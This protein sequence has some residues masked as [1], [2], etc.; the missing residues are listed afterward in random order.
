MSASPDLGGEAFDVLGAAGDDDH[1]VAVEGGGRFGR[2]ELDEIDKPLGEQVGDPLTSVAFGVDDVR[3]AD[4]LQDPA[5][6]AGDRF[7]PDQSGVPSRRRSP[8]SRPLS[9]GEAPSTTTTLACPLIASLPSRARV[10]SLAYCWP[11]D[12]ECRFASVLVACFSQ[13]IRSVEQGP[14]EQRLRTPTG[15]DL[16][17]MGDDRGVWRPHRLYIGVAV[18]SRPGH[19][20]HRRHSCYPNG[21][22]PAM[23][24]AAGMTPQDPECFRTDLRRASL[25]IRQR[26]PSSAD[27]LG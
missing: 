8:R 6:L 26:R 11:N 4:P 5:M 22:G 16:V 24:L 23:R 21:I 27:D 19:A 20:P 14:G 2:A 12:I 18:R 25:S 7:H 9:P 17:W 15:Y 13:L 1:V 3:R 10:A